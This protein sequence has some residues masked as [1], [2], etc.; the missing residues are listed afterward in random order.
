MTIPT[1][2]SGSCDE[3]EEQL[4]RSGALRNANSILL[5]RQRAELDLTEARE[6]LRDE[7]R[8]LELLHRTGTAIASLLDLQKVIQTMTEACI[9]LT[10]AKFAAFAYTE[11]NAFGEGV[12][13]SNDLSD[14]PRYTAIAGDHGLPSESQPVRSFLSVPVISRSGEVIGKLRLGHTEPDIFTDRD[15]RLTIGVAAQAAIAIDN[16]RLYQAAQQEIERRERAEAALKEADRRKDEFLATLAHELRNPL[17]PIW[18]AALVSKSPSATEAEK[19]W[20]HDVILRQVQAMSL[21]LDDLLDV[22][23]ITRGM[24][25]LRK[26]AADLGSIVDAAVETARP[27]I[28]SKRHTLSITLPPQP[29]RL[30]V[31]P[32]RIS[33]VLSNL[34][35]NAAKY[36]DPDGEIR[37]TAYLSAETVL[38]RVADSGIGI[39]PEA[40][41]R[42]FTM[43]SQ[44]IPNRERL[45]GGLGIGLALARGLVELHGGVIEVSSSG[46]GQGSE[47]TV[48]L[49][50]GDANDVRG[51]D[52]RAT[53]A[54]GTASGRKVLVADDNQDAADS[55]A[56]ILRLEGHNVTVAHNG[57]DALTHFASFRPEFALL[58]IGM[59]GLSGYEVARRIRQAPEGRAATLIAVTG[60]GQDSDKAAAR[61]AGFDLHFTKPLDP[62]QVID[63]LRTAPRS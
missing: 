14:D 10:G 54:P 46:L 7:S 18:Q 32:L 53:T 44:V 33:Q 27:L 5:A 22:S 51:S 12:I 45:D 39:G 62:Q 49:P 3:D 11:A 58:D 31:D 30:V 21:L 23:R 25:E 15:E 60:W 28:D 19:R 55:L 63:L 26:T 24:L 35:T 42:I 4:L 40:L 17:A 61:S 47:F 20:S 59:P 8:V 56:M 16:A 36:T 50:L 6:A 48:R 52:A 57:A 13:R 38:I 37:L 43:F 1:E 29:L 2:P 34:L 9:I 41:S